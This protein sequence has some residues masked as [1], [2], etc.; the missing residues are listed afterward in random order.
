MVMTMI[1]QIRAINSGGININAAAAKTT[2]AR[3]RLANISAAVVSTDPKK[4]EAYAFAKRGV[5]RLGFSL[6]SIAEAGGVRALDQAMTEKK[7][8]TQ[9]RIALKSALHH[10]GA[11]A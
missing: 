5:E 7:W 1:P 8:S 11:I 3:E 4:R 6:D 10:V 9:E 2:T